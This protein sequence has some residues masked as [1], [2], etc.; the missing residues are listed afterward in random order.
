MSPIIP[1]DKRV[2]TLL[3]REEIRGLAIRYA[4]GVW[5][6]DV[7]AV[8]ELFAQDGAMDTG[9]GDPVRGRAAI[10]AAYERTF[11]TDDFFPFVHN[12]VIEIDGDT[13]TGSCDLD[14]RAVINGERMSG[15]GSYDD[16]YIRTPDGWK[17]QAR[18]LE[19]RELR[20]LPG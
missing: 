20:K 9:S 15:F 13:A 14:L 2:Q 19:M 12:H 5:R 7:T 11:A 8:A 18:T 1:A 10:R 3:D 6:K 4:H 17:F 16:R